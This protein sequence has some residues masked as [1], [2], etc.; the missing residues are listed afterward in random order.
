MTARDDVIKQAAKVLWI[1][2]QDDRE[3]AKQVVDDL[4]SPADDWPEEAMDMAEQARAVYPV[5]RDAVLD[6]VIATVDTSP[7]VTW[8]GSGGAKERIRGMKGGTE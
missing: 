7:A 1:A 8:A 4:F 2:Q 6:E 3:W 5:I